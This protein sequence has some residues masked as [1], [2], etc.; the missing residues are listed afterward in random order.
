M[1][2]F[3]D[4]TFYDLA[5]SLIAVGLIDRILCELPE[6]MVGPKGWLLRTGE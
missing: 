3:A 4:I 6:S 1:T 2:L 5:L